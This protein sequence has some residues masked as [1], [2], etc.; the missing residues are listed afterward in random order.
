L[1]AH[2]DD[3][4]GGELQISLKREYRVIEI[5]SVRLRKLII[6]NSDI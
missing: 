6:V 4:E 2:E 3:V 1:Q 5:P